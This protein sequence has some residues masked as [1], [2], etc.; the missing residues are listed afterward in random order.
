[1]NSTVLSNEQIAKLSAQQR[2]ELIQA[3]WD[4]LDQDD[5]PITPAHAAELERRMET[6]EQDAATAEPWD[7]VHKRIERSLP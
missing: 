6:H 5:L 2:L 7:V 3:L 1:M 4:S